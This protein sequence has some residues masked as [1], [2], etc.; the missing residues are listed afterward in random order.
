MSSGGGV[1]STVGCEVG[2]HEK[3]LEL[4]RPSLLWH[5]GQTGLRR[6]RLVFSNEEVGSLYRSVVGPVPSRHGPLGIPNKY[7]PIYPRR[8][9]SH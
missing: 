1:L 6:E 4:R 7:I 3:N 8:A 5:R 9:N 2:V